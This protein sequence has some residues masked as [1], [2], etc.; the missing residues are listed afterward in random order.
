MAI[1]VTINELTRA[2]R[3]HIPY[4]TAH[5]VETFTLP[6][7]VA[8][9]TT[10]ALLTPDRETLALAFA[11]GGSVT[12]NTNT[13][14]A[15]DYFATARVGES[16]NALMV[17]GDTDS[18]QTIIQVVVKAN[19]LDDL[20]PPPPLAPKYPTSEE[21]DAILSAMRA[22]ESAVGDFTAEVRELNTQIGETAAKFKSDSD[23][24]LLAMGEAI[25]E[26]GR[27]VTA[28]DTALRNLATTLSGDLEKKA[29]TLTGA[30]E[31]RT[32]ELTQE[33]TQHK[34]DAVADLNV[35]KED[36]E[37]LVESANAAAENANRAVEDATDLLGMVPAV[38]VDSEAVLAA[39]RDLVGTDPG[40]L[41]TLSDEI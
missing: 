21:L 23:A 3:V 31:D 13:Q 2:G 39:S 30:L 38:A 36:A 8:D 27:D 4:L 20:A 33:L 32:T 19:P 15:V 24:A 1:I 9:G 34:D 12:L 28:A 35:I 40:D 29:E 37:R 7:S 26:F 41:V 11:S 6:E 17:I 10:V 18:V 5:T 14:Q 25:D 16:K 22:A